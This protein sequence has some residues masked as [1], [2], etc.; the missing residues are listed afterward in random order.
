M[1]WSGTRNA[2]FGSHAEQNRET[3][4]PAPVWLV[5]SGNGDGRLRLRQEGEGLGE[6]G[7]LGRKVL[8]GTQ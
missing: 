7:E 5:Q 8:R 3:S 1:A 6:E 4:T 2:E